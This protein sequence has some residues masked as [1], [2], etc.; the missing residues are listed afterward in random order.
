MN[1]YDDLIEEYR[2][3]ADN[4]FKVITID[5]TENFFYYSAEIL[6]SRYSNSEGTILIPVKIGL[7]MG[8]K[9]IDKFFK[10]FNLS[11]KE[12]EYM[13]DILV[14]NNLV[15]KEEFHYFKDE[16]YEEYRRNVG[17]GD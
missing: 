16:E 13:I 12:L 11:G 17:Y 5:F 15:K 3:E 2:L 7:D 8:F 4:E 1:K 6:Y 14:K 10:S 9:S